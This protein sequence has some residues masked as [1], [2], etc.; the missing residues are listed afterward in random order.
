[1]VMEP[2]AGLVAALLMLYSG[3]YALIYAET[4]ED[5]MYWATVLQI[6][7]YGETG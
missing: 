4:G 1:M 3:N 7:W 2:F 5:A 6:T